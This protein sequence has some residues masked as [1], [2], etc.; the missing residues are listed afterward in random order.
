MDVI[1]DVVL[2]WVFHGFVVRVL[3]TSVVPRVI[4]DLVVEKWTCWEEI[5]Q[6]CCSCAES[7]MRAFNL[8][9]SFACWPAVA[10]YCI[11]HYYEKSKKSNATPTNVGGG[12]NEALV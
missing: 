11:R 7:I 3:W 9:V 2:L 5:Y 8:L 12:D 1:M 6:F 4:P 10:F